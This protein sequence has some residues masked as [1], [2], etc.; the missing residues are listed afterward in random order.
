MG[1]SAF[2]G[3]DAAVGDG[4]GGGVGVAFDAVLVSF[5]SWYRPCF[6]FR[7]G[8]GVEDDE[9][10]D[11]DESDDDDEDDEDEWLRFLAVADFSSNFSSL[12]RIIS[13]K[14]VERDKV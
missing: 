3:C 14:F 10:D 8:E 11:D 5:L 1:S 12:W 9:D 7:F 13:A 2:E 4:S 6:D